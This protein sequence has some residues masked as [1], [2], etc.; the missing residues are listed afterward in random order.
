[1]DNFFNVHCWQRYVHIDL[2]LQEP[3][4][5]GIG[6]FIEIVGLLSGGLIF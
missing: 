6:S 1:M 3:V 4:V 5:K 2:S